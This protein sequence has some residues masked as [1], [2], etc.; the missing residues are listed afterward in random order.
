M[1]KALGAL[2][3]I[4]SELSHLVPSAPSSSSA[5]SSSSLGRGLHGAIDSTELTEIQA[6]RLALY[7][8]RGQVLRTGAIDSFWL[9]AFLNHRE[10]SA[11]IVERESAALRA[12]IDIEVIDSDV[13]PPLIPPSFSLLPPTL[14]SS[15]PAM[16]VN[17]RPSTSFSIRFYF[18]ENPWFHDTCLVRRYMT[19]ENSIMGR[20]IEPA[21]IDWKPGRKLTTTLQSSEQDEQGMPVYTGHAS[22]F[23]TWLESPDDEFEIGS[24]IRDEVNPNAIAL[25]FGTFRPEEVDD[26]LDFQ[27]QF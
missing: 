16:T 13:S 12:L 22:T 4:Q 10:M 24:L 15:V 7:A 27:E 20:Q 25:F 11:R 17:L 19:F 26:D 9:S 23:F 1:E 8:R 2:V 14:S 3:E 18:E 21:K 6:Q 5:L